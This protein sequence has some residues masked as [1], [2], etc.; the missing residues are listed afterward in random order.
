MGVYIPNM[1]MPKSCVMCRLYTDKFTDDDGFILECALGEYESANC[2]LI[3]IELDEKK[4]GY[5]Q[6]MDITSYEKAVFDLLV[7]KPIDL[8]RCGECKHSKEWYRDHRLCYLWAETGIPVFEDGYCSY[9][10]RRAD[11]HT[12]KRD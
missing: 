9:G 1:E 12:D 6:D 10:E 3:E 11:E 8:V 7:D 5:M 2:P 4:F